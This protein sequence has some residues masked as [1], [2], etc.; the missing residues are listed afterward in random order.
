M[1]YMYKKVRKETKQNRFKKEG[2]KG[3]KEELQKKLHTDLKKKIYSEHM[4][5]C[6]GFCLNLCFTISKYRHT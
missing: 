4:T 3:Q 6:C 5:Q 2:K 1:T